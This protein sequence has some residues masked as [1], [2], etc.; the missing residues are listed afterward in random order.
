[1]NVLFNN[2]TNK[3][4]NFRDVGN[5]DSVLGVHQAICEQQLPP[6]GGVVNGAMILNDSL[7]GNMSI[8]TIENTLKPK[9]QGS[10]LL[11][12]L[13]RD[14]KELD[15]F[16]LVGS[17]T[18]PIGNPGQTAYGAAA[19][20]MAS[21]VRQR[22]EQFNLP[23]SVIHPGAIIGLGYLES[24]DRAFLKSLTARMGPSHISERDFHELFAE[25]ILAGQP[26]SGRDP[27]VIAG[28]RQI[29]PKDY[30][31]ALCYAVPKLW[32]FINHT[33]QYSATEEA[34]IASNTSSIK[35]QLE[36]ATSNEQVVEIISAGLVTKLRTKLGLSPD[37]GN[38]SL[39]TQLAELG[40]DSLIALDLRS[41]FNNEIGVDVSILEILS[42][43]SIGD[44]VHS[45]TL[46]RSED[47]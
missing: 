13:Y 15:F 3:F 23:G 45:A 44:L 33:A 19:T 5:R 25:G 9:V 12:E 6:V 22:R 46:R 38:F 39:K 34:L 16:I 4:Y 17:V 14:P 35:I 8:S 37:Q 28:Y 36:Q 30:P 41:W 10:I 32:S 40:V 31:D 29:N 43:V 26:D 20:F 24:V 11:N 7:F 27:E 1:M 47:V 18:G 21:L 42:G 2:V